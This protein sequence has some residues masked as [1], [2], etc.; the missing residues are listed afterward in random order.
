MLYCFCYAIDSTIAIDC[1]GAKCH[2]VLLVEIRRSFSSSTSLNPSLLCRSCVQLLACALLTHFHRDWLLVG[3][4]RFNNSSFYWTW[5]PDANSMTFSS[6][7]SEVLNFYAFRD[8]YH[9]GKQ[10]CNR[11]LFAKM[12]MAG[13]FFAWPPT[14]TPDLTLIYAA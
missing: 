9:F 13:C 10:T 2:L 3:T 7:L 14:V 8:I 6:L 12:L 5:P 1:N 11:H 4:S